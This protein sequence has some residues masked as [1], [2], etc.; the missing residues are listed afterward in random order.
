MTKNIE[1]VRPRIGQRGTKVQVVIGG[2]S[3]AEPREIVF[4]R[5]GICA[6]DIQPST[7]VPQIHFSH[8]G[9]IVEE[10]RATFEI[11]ADCPLGEHPFRLLTATE[12][13][14]IGTFHVSP[15]PVVDEEE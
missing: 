12:L 10:V 2:I 5:P 1:T 14:C 11:A 6:T 9:T 13:T 8:G 7:S 4:F 3:L 15:F